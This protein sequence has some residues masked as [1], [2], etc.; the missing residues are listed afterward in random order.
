MIIILC[1][2]LYVTKEEE[3]YSTLDGDDDDDDST[4]KCRECNLNWI[5]KNIKK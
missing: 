4:L 5:D 1:R 2:A 3:R